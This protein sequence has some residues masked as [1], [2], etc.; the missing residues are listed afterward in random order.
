MLQF[1]VVAGIGLLA[2]SLVALVRLAII[3]APLA[4]SFLVLLVLNDIHFEA[5]FWFIVFCMLSDRTFKKVM[6]YQ[7]LKQNSFPKQ[8]IG[9]RGN[10]VVRRSPR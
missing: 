5:A 3:S 2:V 9:G 7:N 1:G 8:I 10:V 6:E 4:M